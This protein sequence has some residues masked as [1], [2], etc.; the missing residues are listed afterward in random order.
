MNKLQLAIAI[1]AD[2]GVNKTY[3]Y[4]ALIAIEQ[5][6][7]A[8]GFAGRAVV[9]D[10]FGTFLPRRVEG[11]RTGRI[12]GAGVVTYDNWKLID[13]PAQQTEAGFVQSAAAR[14]TKHPSQMALV[15]QS[16]KKLVLRSL[17]RGVSVTSLGHGG[18][19][20]GRRKARIYYNDDGTVSSR[21]PAKLV[22]KYHGS[23]EGPHQ[24]FVGLA[25][26]V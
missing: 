1:A 2:C 8:D 24:K 25:G 13:N 6:L 21:H 7:D 12:F 18:F 9:W 22:V 23:K 20:V 3:A 11:Q 16:Y 26:L 19:R 15:L 5:Q 4:R 10:G 14:T 17:R